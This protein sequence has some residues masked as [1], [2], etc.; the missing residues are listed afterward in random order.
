MKIFMKDEELKH[1]SKKDVYE[2]EEVIGIIEDM[3]SE[4]ESLEEKLKD[5]QQDIEDNYRPIPYK[6]QIGYNEK[7]F[8]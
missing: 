2:W 7:D 3:E 4:I 6:E 5:L 1:F 8:Y